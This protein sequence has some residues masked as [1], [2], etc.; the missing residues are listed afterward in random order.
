MI[1]NVAT[2]WPMPPTL[3]TPLYAALATNPCISISCARV[4]QR[5]P[6]SDFGSEPNRPATRFVPA[7]AWLVGSSIRL[8]VV[9]WEVAC[10]AIW[11]M[12]ES[13]GCLGGR[14][15]GWH[16]F[17]RVLSHAMFLG[18]LFGAAIVFILKPP[19]EIGTEGYPRREPQS[20][21]EPHCA[22]ACAS[23]AAGACVHASACIR[24]RTHFC[25]CGRRA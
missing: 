24:H 6:A 19:L 2:F 16:A 17:C 12:A 10:W 1:F 3:S 23:V 25:V 11:P 22:C 9:R 18:G 4:C 8:P 5:E 14:M 15:V 13:A 20:R 21:V 7:A